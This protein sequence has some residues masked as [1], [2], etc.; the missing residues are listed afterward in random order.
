[1]KLTS[2]ERVFL[3]N[4]FKILEAL[5]PDEAYI[6]ERHRTALECGYTLQYGWITEWFSEELSEAECQEVWDIL[7]MYRSLKFAYNRLTNK[8]EI[9]EEE[10]RFQGF[11]ENEEA[12][13]MGY[14]DYIIRDLGR[15]NELSG[16]DLNAHR[17][18]LE[19]YRK[20]LAEWNRSA[21]KYNLEKDDIL[22]II[23]V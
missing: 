10:I 19:R 21:D 20:M 23:S 9:T 2:K 13:L 6:Y 5:Y 15:Y 8:N 7:E 14:A 12:R 1:M 17:P 16:I 22:R 4:Q 11:D 3:A 18:C